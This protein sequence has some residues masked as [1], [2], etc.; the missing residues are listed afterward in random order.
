MIE[1]IAL[2]L[3]PLFPLFPLL[4]AVVVVAAVDGTSLL[5]VFSTLFSTFISVGLSMVDVKAFIE[6][7]VMTG[8]NVLFVEPMNNK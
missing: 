6:V 2:P 3:F 1:F 5:L 4:G 8:L 7:S